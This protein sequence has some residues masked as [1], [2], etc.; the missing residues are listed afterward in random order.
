MESLLTAQQ[1][2]AHLAVSVKLIHALCREGWLSYVQISFRGERRFL[3]QQIHAFI[4][5]QT[6]QAPKLV[7]KQKPRKLPFLP[8]KAGEEELVGVTGSGLRKKIRDLCQ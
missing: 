2:A 5:A 3:P 7:D 6:V 1:A 4:E 8:R